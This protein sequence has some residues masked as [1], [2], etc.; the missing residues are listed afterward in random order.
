MNQ[1][2]G[3][4]SSESRVDIPHRFQLVVHPRIF[5]VG[6]I[7]R[8][9]EGGGGREEGSAEEESKEE[10]EEEERR[11]KMASAATMPD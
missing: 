4:T 3:H 11:S 2:R 10:E 5:Q 1:P 9:F 7:G 8:S 6:L